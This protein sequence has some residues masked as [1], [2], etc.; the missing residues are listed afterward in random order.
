VARMIVEVMLEPGMHDPR[1][2]AVSRACRR[3][4]FGQAGGS[5][6]QSGL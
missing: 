6:R 5:G 1:G 2:Q 3:L 4:E